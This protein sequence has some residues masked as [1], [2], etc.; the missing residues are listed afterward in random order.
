MKLLVQ[1]N[2]RC[3]SL[4]NHSSFLSGYALPDQQVLKITVLK[5]DYNLYSILNNPHH[6]IK[7]KILKLQYE[8]CLKM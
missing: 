6:F 1:Y 4:S 5:Q 3:L 2:T 7:L 8:L